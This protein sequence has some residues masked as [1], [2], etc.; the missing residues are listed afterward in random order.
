[1][2]P[3]YPFA[4]RYRRVSGEFKSLVQVSSFFLDTSAP[5]F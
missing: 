4:L 1:M 3:F 2:L 5:F